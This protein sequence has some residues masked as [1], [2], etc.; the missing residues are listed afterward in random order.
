[1]RAYYFGELR[2]RTDPLG[3]TERFRNFR[4][5]LAAATEPEPVRRRPRRHVTG[6]RNVRRHAD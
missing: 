4:R 6:L 2:S 3:E 1:M 5:A